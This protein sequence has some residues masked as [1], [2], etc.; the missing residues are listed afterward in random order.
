MSN[1][2]NSDLKVVENSATRGSA[3]VPGQAYS[4]PNDL[5]LPCS[6]WA[7]EV[8]DPRE[9]HEHYNMFAMVVEKNLRRA[10][11]K[12]LTR[13]TGEPSK[14]EKMSTKGHMSEGKLVCE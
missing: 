8:V 12:H 4:S 7:A 2:H 9:H 10:S 14:K 11:P 6:S 3:S 13:G 5:R 1:D